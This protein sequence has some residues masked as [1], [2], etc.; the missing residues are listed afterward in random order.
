MLSVL[1]PPGV[2]GA[3]APGEGL[4]GG[5]L[6]F[7]P[8]GRWTVHRRAELLAAETCARLGG[9]EWWAALTSSNV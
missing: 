9:F 8:T 7:V 6:G 2:C 1:V 5:E 4:C 3:D